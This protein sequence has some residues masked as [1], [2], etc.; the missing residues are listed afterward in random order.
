MKQKKRF[1]VA[2]ATNQHSLEQSKQILEEFLKIKLLLNDS[3]FED[4]VLYRYRFPGEGH[5]RITL[6]ENY[7]PEVDEWKDPDLKQYQVII[8]FLGLELESA[9]ID[10]LKNNFEY[11]Y[12]KQ[13]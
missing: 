3:S 1:I 9:E 5:A 12:S 7:M 2:L 6:Y 11:L 10:L 8:N 13:I 4:G